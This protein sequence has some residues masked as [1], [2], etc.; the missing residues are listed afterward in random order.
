MTVATRHLRKALSLGALVLTL[1]AMPATGQ[2]L[3]RAGEPY[4]NYAYEGYRSYE[5]IFFGRDRTP[6]FDN[7][8]QFVMNGISVFELQ[9]LRTIDPMAG[10]IIAKPGLY[11]NYLNRLVIADDKYRGTSTRLIIGD[12]IRAKFTSLTLDLAAMNG[13]RLDS[14]F[15]RG[16]LVLLASRVD[17]PIFEALGNKDHNI[18]GDE[19]SE[20]RPRW[21]TYLLGG[22]LRTQRP[23]LDVGVSWVNQ[24]RTDSLRKLSENSLKGVVPTT[25]RPPEWIVV[26]VSDQDPDDGVGVRVKGIALTLNGRRVEHLLGPYDKLAPDAATLTVTEH[27]DR[28]IIP[29]IDRDNSDDLVIQFPHLEPNPQGLYE[30]EGSGSLL[31]WFRVPAMVGGQADTNAVNR[32][33]V[34][35]A[36]AGDYAIELSEVFDGVSANPATYFY[37]AAAS[38]GRPDNLDGFRQV[39][40]HYGRQTGRT[41]VGAHM[42]LDVRGLSLHGEYVR[43]F[44]FRAYPSLIGSQLRHRQDESNAW[45]VTFRRDWTRLTVGGEVFD[46]ARDYSTLLNVQ[47]DDFQ[48]YYRFLTSPFIFPT[49]FNEPRLPDMLGTNRAAPTNTI[50]FNTVD[51]NDDKDQYPDTYFLRKTTNVATG[52]RFIEDPDGVFPGLDADL[53]GRP[54]INENANFIPDYFEPF[55]LYRVNPDAYDYGED[56]NNNGVIDE[57]E[58][59]EKPD[60]PYDADRRGVHGFAQMTPGRDLKLT[61]GYHRTSAPYGGGKA[62]SMYGR[63]EYQHRIPFQVELY[64]VERLK[65]VHDDIP[66]AVYGLGRDP[67]YFEPEVVP[68]VRPTDEELRNPLGFPILQKDP[69]LMRDSRVSTTYLR[70][71]LIRVPRLD[72]EVSVKYDRNAQQ[73]TGY[74]SGNTIAD[75][76]MVLKSQYEWYPWGAL[77]VRPQVKLMRQRLSDDRARVLEIDETYF[78]PILRLEYPVSDR[79]SVKAGAQG[80]PFLKSRYRNGVTEGVDFDSEVYLIQLSNTSTYVGYQVNVNLGYERQIRDFLES[81]REAQDIDYNRLFL[82]VIAGLRPLF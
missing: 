8:G 57:R 25:G 50:E 24:Y 59:D 72:V 52:G 82:R 74:Q 17:K 33:H 9:E 49:N 6:Q 70:A 55:L 19:S 27:P 12:R 78:Y 15:G 62:R 44:S 64:G 1:S 65:A 5:S 77:A 37:E 76:A 71:K 23:G 35:V 69:L 40:V 14:Q 81:D 54:D 41:L 22:D 67:I 30:T 73:K 79:T 4:V 28:T 36:V 46:V 32:A 56:M 42:N 45:F 13:I 11:Q 29:P 47:D 66:D 38:R 18:H 75:L 7:L 63:L 53:N 10:S 80:F 21:A 34:D 3:L 31:F 39:R 61:I 43:N 58:N 48:S 16:S 60:Y 68:V 26:R 2:F 51:D 20:F